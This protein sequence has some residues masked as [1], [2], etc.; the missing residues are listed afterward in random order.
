MFYKVY[1]Q[2]GKLKEKLSGD[3]THGALGNDYPPGRNILDSDKYEFKRVTGGFD[4]RGIK[5]NGEYWR[6]FQTFFEN[7]SY[8]TDSKEAADFFDELINNVCFNTFVNNP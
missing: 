6:F 7:Y 8:S 4:W 1:F 2:K 3:E 5:K